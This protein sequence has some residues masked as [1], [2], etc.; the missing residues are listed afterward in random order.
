M[1][2]T[3]SAINMYI[4]KL[5]LQFDNNINNKLLINFIVGMLD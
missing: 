3:A 4:Y 1:M 5:E 2:A